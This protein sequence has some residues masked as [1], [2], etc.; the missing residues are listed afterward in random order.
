MFFIRISELFLILI[1]RVTFLKNLLSI[2]PAPRP[3]TNPFSRPMHQT[4]IGSIIQMIQI[5]ATTTPQPFL[6]PFRLTFPL[7]DFLNKVVVSNI[8][9]LILVI[10]R[11][12]V[13]SVPRSLIIF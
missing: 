4:N 11:I 9:C 12:S 13:V 3:P 6:L 2:Q 1:R 8:G 5:I 7:R 10:N